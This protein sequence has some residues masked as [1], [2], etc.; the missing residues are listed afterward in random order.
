MKLI[1]CFRLRACL[2]PVLGLALLAALMPA[3]AV[4]YNRDTGDTKSRELAN[5]PPFSSRANIP[6]CTAVLIAPN[7]LLSASHCVNYAASGTVN[8]T[9]NGQTLT[10]AQARDY[11]CQLAGPRA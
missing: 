9:W 7:V 3:L 10:G 6:G 2:V 4:M 11:P 8:A 1:R 5:L